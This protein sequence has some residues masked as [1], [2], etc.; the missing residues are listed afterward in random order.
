MRLRRKSKGKY[1]RKKCIIWY[2]I[3][4]VLLMASG[5]I[6]WTNINITTTHIT[7]KN[8]KIGDD[9]TDFRIAQVSDL[10]NHKWGNKLIKCLKRESPDIIVITG[11]LV[12]S[13][14]THIDVAMKF[15][16]Q[17]KKIAPIY[18]VTGN[19]EAWMDNYSEL[20]NKL[21]GADVHI[22]DNKSELIEKGN[23]KI[24]IIGIKDPDFGGY[25]TA[26][27]I[28]KSIEA[29]N[30]QP[31]I[32]SEYYNIVLCHRPEYFNDYVETHAELVLTGH[33]HGGQIR[34]PFLGGVVAPNQGF[35]PD[36]TEGVYH[37]DKTDMVVSRGLGNSVIP[38][39]INNMP[40]LVI[41][42]LDK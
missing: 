32:M 28:I 27:N 42:T 22:M 35:F 9:F 34:L 4:V 10:H 18:Y 16:K 30:K 24:N 11:D 38:V 20:E 15:I 7:I 8:G 37:Q 19:H 14:H 36:Y 3:I 13:S 31:L 25:S 2:V 17:A 26:D 29:T 6:V 40:E 21:V 12:D 23:S 39:R 41:I 33:A 5:W 1:L